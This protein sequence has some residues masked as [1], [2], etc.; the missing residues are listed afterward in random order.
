MVPLLINSPPLTP[1]EI[2]FAVRTVM[3]PLEDTDPAPLTT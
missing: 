1:A 3:L 2:V